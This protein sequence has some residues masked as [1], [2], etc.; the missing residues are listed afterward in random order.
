MSDERP[1]A[2]ERA[3]TI[4][5]SLFHISR[6]A[7]DALGSEELLSIFSDQIRAAERAAT[8]AERERCA[9][10]D[11]LSVPCSACGV[12]TDTRCKTDGEHYSRWR[13]AIR[14][15]TEEKRG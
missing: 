3:E 12:E 1:T 10:I 9:E 13:A 6:D 5:R 11:P 4:Y 15:D 14:D 2:E 7:F 8:L